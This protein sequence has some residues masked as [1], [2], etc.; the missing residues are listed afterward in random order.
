MKVIRLK[1]EMPLASTKQLI[2]AILKKDLD[3]FKATSI[4]FFR[5]NQA[6]YPRFSGLIA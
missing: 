5:N 6:Y 2:G 3:A 1:L 4:Q